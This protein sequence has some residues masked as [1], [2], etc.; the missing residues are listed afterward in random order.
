MWRGVRSAKLGLA[1]PEAQSPGGRGVR[2]TQVVPD[3]APAG[4]KAHTTRYRADDEGGHQP[5]MFADPPPDS[6][7]YCGAKE[8][9]EHFQE[10]I[11]H[12]QAPCGNPKLR[13]R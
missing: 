4:V 1:A 12:V 3:K 10:D 8:S 7:E 11:L 5:D 2:L 13:R 9:E 6:A